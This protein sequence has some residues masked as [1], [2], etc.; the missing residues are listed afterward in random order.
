MSQSKLWKAIGEG[1]F[2]GEANKIC[3]EAMAAAWHPLITKAYLSLQ[4]PLHWKGSQL[5][6]LFK[7][8][9]SSSLIANWREIMLS[10]PDT[11]MVAKDF[12]KDIAGPAFA[13]CPQHK[14]GE[15]FNGGSCEQPHL[16]LGAIAQ[17]AAL[18]ARS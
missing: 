18:P 13:G 3:P 17:I 15:G 11:M 5:H 4:M 16:M 8:K 12:R 7:N 10:D 6:T 14:F 2:V 9:G 1:L